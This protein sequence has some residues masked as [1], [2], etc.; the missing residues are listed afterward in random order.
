M[1]DFK[2]VSLKCGEIMRGVSE[3]T[4]ALYVTR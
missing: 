1:T 3:S 2:V 4:A